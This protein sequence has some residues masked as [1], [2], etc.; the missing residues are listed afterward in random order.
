MFL[1]ERRGIDLDSDRWCS[2]P[3]QE[4]LPACVRVC[5]L[6]YIYIFTRYVIVFSIWFCN[7][8]T[9]VL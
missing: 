6:K 8:V 5:V 9:V 4:I 2:I 3:V 7:M 1:I